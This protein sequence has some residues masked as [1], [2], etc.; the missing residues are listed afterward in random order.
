MKISFIVSLIIASLSICY[1]KLSFYK[2]SNCISGS[3][4]AD[5]FTKDLFSSTFGSYG[6][7]NFNG[8]GTAFTD[9]YGYTGIFRKDGSDIYVQFKNS[10]CNYAIG[11]KYTFDAYGCANT[12]T[13]GN[14]FSITTFDSYDNTFNGY[15][16]SLSRVSSGGSDCTKWNVTGGYALKLD[17]CY[18]IGTPSVRYKCENGLPF[19]TLDNVDC[20]SPNY[21]PIGNLCIYKCA[22]GTTSAGVKYGYTLSLLML[23]FYLLL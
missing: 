17:Y 23:M 3:N 11:E 5:F 14:S 16:L 20:N 12:K 21:T 9:E 6:C 22:V 8:Y 4:V 2:G 18:T 10:A 1:H 7:Q 13:G 19:K 15:L